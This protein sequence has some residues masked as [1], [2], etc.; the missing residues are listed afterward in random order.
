MTK[1]LKA[2]RRW[3]HG[4]DNVIVVFHKKSC[5]YSR[6]AIEHLK[7][8]SKPL[9]LVDVDADAAYKLCKDAMQLATG[10]TTLPC[11]FEAGRLIGGRDEAVNFYNRFIGAAGGE[12]KT[13]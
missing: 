6:E 13:R 9:V 5:P 3:T 10:H 12:N 1:Y 11:I 7:T 8:L 4:V 2:L